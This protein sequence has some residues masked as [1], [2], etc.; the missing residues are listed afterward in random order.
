MGLGGSRGSGDLEMEGLGVGG[1]LELD[2]A[3]GMVRI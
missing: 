1:V 2:W 3:K